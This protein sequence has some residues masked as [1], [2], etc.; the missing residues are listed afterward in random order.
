MINIH[1]IWA[2]DSTGGIGKDGNLPWHIPEDLKNFKKITQDSTIIMGRNTWESLPIKPLPKR[3]NI[4]IS[5]HNIK[6]IEHYSSIDMCIEK[7]NE[8]YIKKIFVI[9]GAQIYKEFIYKSDELHITFIDLETKDVDTFF[10]LSLK[11]I[12]QMFTKKKEYSLSENATY[13]NWKRI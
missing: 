8:E 4:V 6:N 9:G 7:L 12:K 13:T 3:R 11:K 10:P 2:Q 5:S 1:L